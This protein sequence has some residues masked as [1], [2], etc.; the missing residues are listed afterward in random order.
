M[1]W[2]AVPAVEGNKGHCFQWAK[3]GSCR[4]GGDCRYLHEPSKKGPTQN[5]KAKG[6][7]KG[8]SRVHRIALVAS[9]LRRM[10]GKDLAPF[11]LVAN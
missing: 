11:Q 6:Q 1:T 3:H 9:P 10:Q 7:G 5:Q 8:S 4:Y 2:M